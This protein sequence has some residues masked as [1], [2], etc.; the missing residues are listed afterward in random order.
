MLVRYLPSSISLSERVCS[1]RITRFFGLPVFAPM[2]SMV[3]LSMVLELAYNDNN[4][5]DGGL[6]GLHYKYIS[7]SAISFT[8]I[9]SS[10]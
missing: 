2:C 10:Q 6:T 7:I 1:F 9:S 5:S 4:E 8:S 3:I